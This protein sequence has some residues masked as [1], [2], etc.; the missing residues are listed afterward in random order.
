MKT[1]ANRNTNKTLNMA[2][3]RRIYEN[4]NTGHGMGITQTIRQRLNEKAQTKYTQEANERS[5]NT[6]GN[7]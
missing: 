3:M 1:L 7:S 5:G 2:M 6:W 4:L